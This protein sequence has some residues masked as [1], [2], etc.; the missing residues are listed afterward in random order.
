MTNSLTLSQFDNSADQLSLIGV[1]VQNYKPKIHISENSRSETA[2][3]PT[4]CLSTQR[5]VKSVQFVTLCSWRVRIYLS[6]YR[7]HCSVF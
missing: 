6:I 2:K 5:T 1:K 4:P 3:R 7:K